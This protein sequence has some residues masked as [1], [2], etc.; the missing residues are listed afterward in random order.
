VQV[1]QVLALRQIEPLEIE[2]EIGI[3][4][5]IGIGIIVDI[6]AD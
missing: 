3:G 4:I 5:G 1:R 2:I 6:L